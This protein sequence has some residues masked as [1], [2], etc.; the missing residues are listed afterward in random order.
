MSATPPARRRARGQRGQNREGAILL[1]VL[2]ALAL[3]VAAAAVVT[4]ALNA[5]LN[6]LERQ[7]L[8]TQSLNLAASVLAEVQLGIRSAT[9]DAA[10]P[11][12]APFQDWTWELAVSPAENGPELVNGLT[13]VEV[14]IRNTKSP[15]VQRLAQLMRLGGNSLSSTNSSSSAKTL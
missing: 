5:A 4:T 13:K 10:K 15:Q 11:L 9:G 6:S 14:V 8:S 3:F 7:K 2:L 12:E 1:E